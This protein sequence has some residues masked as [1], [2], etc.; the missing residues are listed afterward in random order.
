MVITGVVV[1]TDGVGGQVV[2]PEQ[3]EP[4]NILISG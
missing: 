2:P 4:E 1:C 3:A